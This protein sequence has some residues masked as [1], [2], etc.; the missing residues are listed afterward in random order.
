MA[1]D[2]ELAPK[3]PSVTTPA[4]ESTL[5]LRP[6]TQTEL[7]QLPP[8]LDGRSTPDTR[9]QTSEFYL[10]VAALFEQWVQRRPSPHTQRAYRQDAV[11]FIR[12]LGRHWPGGFVWPDESWKLLTVSLQDVLAWRTS[13]IEAEAAPKTLNRRISSLSSFYKFLGAAAAELRLPITVPNPAHAQFIERT[14]ADPVEETKS[15]SITR[16]RQL[17]GM[18][19]GDSVLEYRDRAILKVMVYVG[20]RIGTVAKLNVS[21]FHQEGDQATL[22]LQEKGHRRRTVGIHFA[23]AEAVAEYLRV[24]GIASGAMFRARLNPRSQKLSER[25]ISVVSLYRLLEGYLSR[26]PS[27]T[28]EVE[29]PDGTKARRCIYTP[30]S[31]RATTATL[32]LDAGVEITKV[33]E[34]LG[35]RH[36][37]TTQIYDKRRRTTSESASHEVP[38]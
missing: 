6:P 14:G 15:L 19:A 12:F 1:R 31:L 36:V 37:T 33:Q 38:I 24:A 26:L 21:D 32:L 27:S 8:I 5:T 7:E 29:A 18:P 34:L 23:A 11:A 3:V 17:M 35:H 10:S 2:S 30:H 4:P 28:K 16:A 9:R 22:R 25:R 13:L 20:A